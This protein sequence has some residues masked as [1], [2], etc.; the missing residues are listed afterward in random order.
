[1]VCGGP[2]PSWDAVRLLS[3]EIQMH[4]ALHPPTAQVRRDQVVEGAAE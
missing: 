4:S 3:N 2:T 1:M